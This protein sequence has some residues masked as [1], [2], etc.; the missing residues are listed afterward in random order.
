VKGACW[1]LGFALTNLNKFKS[2]VQLFADCTSIHQ[3]TSPQK[4]NK[5]GAG[6]GDEALDYSAQ[7]KISPR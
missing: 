4:R 3:Q 1:S 6:P 7:K 5:N 2:S